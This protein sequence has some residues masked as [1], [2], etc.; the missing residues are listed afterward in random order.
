MSA[1]QFSQTQYIL[2]ATVV[3]GLGGVVEQRVLLPPG[4]PGR[5]PTCGH[6]RAFSWFMESH[7]SQ[8]L[9]RRWLLPPPVHTGAFFLTTHLL[10]WISQQNINSWR[11]QPPLGVMENAVFFCYLNADFRRLEPERDHKISFISWE[12]CSGLQK[13]GFKN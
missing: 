6:T 2:D 11:A 12:H 5:W 4:H 13:Y 8:C 3:E 1:F 10:F 9:A 7:K